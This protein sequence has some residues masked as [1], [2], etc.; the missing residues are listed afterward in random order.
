MSEN[1]IRELAD[2]VERT[3]VRYPNRFG[4]VIAGDLYTP[5]G[6]DRGAAHPALVIGAPYGGVKEQGPCVYAEELARRGFVCLTFDPCYMGESS[7]YPRR[8][9][10]PDLFAENFSAGVD[11]L[12]LL[13]FVDRERIAALGIC[14]SGG[15]ALAAAQVDTRIRA[16]ATASMF[17]MSMAAR[18]ATSPKE[19]QARKEALAA[20]RWVDAENGYPEYVPAFPATPIA[21][22]DI[23]ADMPE[24][25]AIWM[26]FY[27]TPRGH[28]PNARGGFTT[29]SDLSFINFDLLAHVDEIAPRPV[30]FVVGSRAHS[31]VFSET[32]F[33][34]AAEP[35]E[36]YVVDGADHIDLYDRVD[37]IPFDKLEEFFRAAFA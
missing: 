29:T 35:K 28:H 6:L 26:R 8:V 2:D 17:D 20:Q 31:N 14:G 3:S 23:P 34:N 16:V 11:Y 9:S 10:S 7:G 15:F 21:L 24:D 27:A 32:T 13:G 12:G 33:A 37:L 36:L 4:H 18:M 22:E 1:Y 30:L 19:L 5:R 25:A